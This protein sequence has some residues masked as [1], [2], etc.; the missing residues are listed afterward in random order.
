VSVRPARIDSPAP[1][2]IALFGA[3]N[4]GKTTLFNSFTGARARVGNFAGVTVQRREGLLEVDGRQIILLDLPGAYSLEPDCEAEA[5]AHH[6]LTG[7][8]AG[9][10]RPDALLLIVDATTLPRSL[11]LVAEALHLDIPKLLVLTMIDEVQARGQHVDVMKLSH[12]LGIP[13][14]GVVGH[15][16]VGVQQLRQAMTHPERWGRPHDLPPLADPVERF[17]WVDR[18]VAQVA[19]RRDGLDPRTE[20]LDRV[21]LHP[22]AGTVIFLCVMVGIFQAIFTLAVPFM[23]GIDGFFGW[24]AQ[25]SFQ[26]L[27]PGLLAGFWANG[28]LAGVGAVLVFLPQIVILFALIHF[29]ED[30]GYMARAAFVVDRVMGWIG[31]QGRSFVPLLSCYACAVPG[32]LAARTISSPRDRLATILVAPLMPCSARLPVYTLLIAAFVPARQVGGV[33]SSQAL[34]MLGL[35]ALGTLTALASAGLFNR[36]LLRGTPSRFYLE[37]PPYRMPTAR[38]LA[39]QV[40]VSAKAFLKR[41]GTI[42]LAA[43]LVFWLFLSLP[44]AVPPPGLDAI[45]QSQYQIQHSLAGTIGRAMEPVIKPLGFDWRIGVGLVASLTAREVIVAT[46]AQIYAVSSADFEGLRK[47]LLRDPHFSLPTAL[48]LLVFFVLAL[49]CTSTITVMGRETGS[50]RWPAFAFGYMLLMA[51]VGSF[52]TYKLSSALM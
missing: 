32:I 1:L 45:Q 18:V 48:S 19:S 25:R 37:L 24:L 5:I 8:L 9:E 22:V 14:L 43:S 46:L 42:I 52:I 16:G 36:T 2:R 12:I 13:V 23:N 17:A 35:Y 34:V 51:Y 47:A 20:R 10:S 27:P 28:V 7:Q 49:Q 39:T 15:R 11:G 31:L 29:L 44:R 30:V 6:V 26:L 4:S 33:L 38:L 41:A 50:L 40:W 21:L 3:P